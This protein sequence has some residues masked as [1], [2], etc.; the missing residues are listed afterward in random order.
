M[1]VSVPQIA[2][3]YAEQILAQHPDD[4]MI[5]LVGHSAGGWYAHALAAAL[6][7]RG[8]PIGMFAVLDSAP[9]ARTHRRIGLILLAGRLL[10]RLRHHLHMLVR[11]PSGEPRIPFVLAGLRGL[12]NHLDTYL[13]HHRD[14]DRAL[15]R[16]AFTEDEPDC[17]EKDFYVVLHRGYR[18]QRLGLVVDVF[19]PL[20]SI[21][22]RRRLWRFY[23]RSGVRTHAI[24]DSHN[25]FIC[26][27][28]APRL[29]QEL[30]SVLKAVESGQLKPAAN[31]RP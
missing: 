14:I 13:L 17:A 24:F 18:P 11:N 15:R 6:L 8:A 1:S 16:A 29:A 30:E 22:A 7:E 19:A 23:A 27:E 9:T 21:R 4:T 28:S 31:I 20:G 10:P 5:H 3:R 12:N 2:A 26:P 25:E